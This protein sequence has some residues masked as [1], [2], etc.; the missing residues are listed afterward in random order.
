MNAQDAVL[1]RAPVSDIIIY[2][3]SLLPLLGS[4]S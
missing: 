4:R 1:T 2:Q 3:A